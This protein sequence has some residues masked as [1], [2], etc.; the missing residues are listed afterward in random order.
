MADNE[1]MA[2]AD[3][4]RKDA[5]AKLDMIADSLG[6]LH[7]RMDSYEEESAAR[8]DAE[9]KARMDKA[10]FDAARKDRFG[11]RKDGEKHDAWKKRHDADEG[12]MAAELAKGGKD[13]ADCAMDAKKARFDAETEER[14]TDAE[15]FDKWAKEEAKEPEHKEDA[16]KDGDDEGEEKNKVAETEGEE[17]KLVEREDAKHD[18]AGK[19]MQAQ[20][21]RLEAMLGKLTREVPAGERDLLAAAQTRADGTLAMYGERATAPLPGEGALAYRK[22]LASKLQGRSERFKT[23]RFD[24]MDEAAFAPIEELVYQDATAAARNPRT[25]VTGTLVPIVTREGGRDVTR[26]QGDIGAWMQHFMSPGQGGFFHR[27]SNG[28]GA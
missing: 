2:A 27:P 25:V 12:G 5:E 19:A 17:K 3:K 20:I 15:S 16:K 23:L 14:M 21:A 26:Y 11:P 4:A 24:T 10:R 6:R 13:S 7:G 9:E 8:K 22:R 28:R 1:E 18:A